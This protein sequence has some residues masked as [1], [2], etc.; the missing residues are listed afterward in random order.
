MIDEKIPCDKESLS[1]LA[2][3]S[4][5]SVRDALSLLD[6]AIVHGKG[7]LVSEEIGKMLG[8]TRE[9]IRQIEKKAITKLRGIDGIGYLR[10]LL[11]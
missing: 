5:G 4:D 2:R 10:E 7:Q 8:L 11:V 1:Y 3:A 9:R 6:Q